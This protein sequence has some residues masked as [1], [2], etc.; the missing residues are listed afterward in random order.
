VTEETVCSHSESEVESMAPVGNYTK[1]KW[2]SV[3]FGEDH[4]THGI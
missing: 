1:W 3:K 4:N 2:K